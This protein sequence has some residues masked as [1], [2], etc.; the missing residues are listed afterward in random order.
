MSR[1]EL[2]L[3]RGG[4]TLI[5]LLVVIAIIALLIGLLLPAVQKVREIA[6]R[7]KCANNLKQI[8]LA[9]F[10]VA[11]TYKSLPPLFNYNFPLNPAGQPLNKDYGGHW[12]SVFLHLLRN[13]EEQN[14]YDY[15][16]PVFNTTNGTIVAVTVPPNPPI[17][18]GYIPQVRQQV[19]P[20]GAGAFKVPPFICPSDT[21]TSDG[22]ASGPDGNTWGV[23]SYGANFLVFGNKSIAGYPN[24]N[25]QNAFW[26]YFDSRNRYPESIPD[27]TSK[28]IMFT[29]KFAICNGPTFGGTAVIGGSLWAYMPVFGPPGNN[30]QAGPVVGFFNSGQ[31]AQDPF[32][33]FYPFL[34]QSQPAD[35]ACDAYA[36]QSSHG[37]GAINVGM[38]DGSVRTQTLRANVAYGT[39]PGLVHSNYSWKSAL[40]P[41]KKF[42]PVTGGT[43]HDTLD[44]DWV[45]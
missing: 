45:D 29:E 18:L 21:T 40:T 7:T 11:D 25:G 22:T 19:T 36:A 39:S 20:A 13:L 12:G 43:D 31:T 37:G 35:G 23:S 5:E 2:R 3:R 38:A 28:T 17:P 4:F 10:Q 24:V 6:N 26:V 33:P 16:D 27:G 9:T 8:S 41:Q 42:L 15:G 14:L 1:S 32:F 30:Y 44:V 34:Y